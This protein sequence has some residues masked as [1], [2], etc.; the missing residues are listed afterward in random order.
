VCK[1]NCTSSCLNPNGWEAEAIST[2]K[3]RGKGSECALATHS[4]RPPLLGLPAGQHKDGAR[5]GAAQLAR[6]CR[7]A[8]R[9]S[10]VPAGNPRAVQRVSGRTRCT[11]P[12]P[13]ATAACPGWRPGP[14]GR[15]RGRPLRAP[16]PALS[17]ESAASRAA[18]PPQ[19]SG[20]AS[21]EQSTQSLPS[22]T[23]AVLPGQGMQRRLR[24]TMA[25]LN[26]CTTAGT[27]RCLRGRVG[28]GHS[29]VCAP[30]VAS[31]CG[32]GSAPGYQVVSSSCVAAG[33]EPGVSLG[34]HWYPERQHTL[35]HWSVPHPQ[36]VGLVQL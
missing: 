4:P 31:R 25:R 35:Q 6:G 24:L 29:R 17:T 8:R 22:S 20:S 18:G 11:A 28:T 19:V 34:Q 3:K 36:A 16:R 23:T 15:S 33:R 9:L 12:P 32:A 30:R 21:P 1:C 5:S 13:P 2:K 26:R 7:Q 14:A 10:A 27:Q